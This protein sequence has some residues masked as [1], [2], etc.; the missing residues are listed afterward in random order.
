MDLH[1]ATDPRGF[2]DIPVDN[3]YASRRSSRSTFLHQF[4]WRH[5]RRDLVVSP[6]VGG[7]ARARELATRIGATARH[8]GQTPRKGGRGSRA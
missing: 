7:V 8:R 3:L 4:E 6:D 5:V 2:F 1:A